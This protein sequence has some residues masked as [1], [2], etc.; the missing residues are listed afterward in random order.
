MRDGNRLAGWQSGSC[1]GLQILVH[2]F[3][4]G[5]GLQKVFTVFR[6]SSAVEQS[7]VNR[8]VACS[9]QAAGAN[10]KSTPCGCFFLLAPCL[11]VGQRPTEACLTGGMRKRAA[12]AVEALEPAAASN[13]ICE[14]SICAVGPIAGVFFIG[15]CY[16]EQTGGQSGA[17]EK[18][19]QGQNQPLLRLILPQET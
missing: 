3:N 12:G 17:C 14:L 8:L 16:P 19:A 10:K 6:L 15:F 7:A 4:S 5:T 9:N 18:S 1:R 13:N 2:R 11:S